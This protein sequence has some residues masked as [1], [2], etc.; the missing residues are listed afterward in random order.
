MNHSSGENASNTPAASSELSTVPRRL[1]VLGIG[2]IMEEVGKGARLV[3]RYP[4]S[5]PPFFLDYRRATDAEGEANGN[6][7]AEHQALCN[8]SPSNASKKKSRPGPSSA[9]TSSNE[10]NNLSGSIDLF[11]DLPARV[12]SKLFRPK[13]PLCGQPLTLNV[14]GTTFCCRAELFDSQ[15][16]TIGVGEDFNHPLVLFSVIVA[17][18]PL[19]PSSADKEIPLSHSSQY[20]F[21]FSGAINRDANAEN[22]QTQSSST[23]NSRSDGAFKTIRCV[24]RNLA[25]LCRV[26]VR[27]ENR[28]RYVSRQCNM[29]QKIRTDY[30]L[31]SS[32][33]STQSLGSDGGE[34]NST[35]AGGEGNSKKGEGTGNTSAGPPPLSPKHSA[36]KGQD[37]NKSNVDV[38]DRSMDC[39]RAQRREY[40][41]N[42]IDIL[43]AASPPA[44]D[45]SHADGDFAGR[46]QHGNLA[47]ELAQVFH[48][49]ASP[50]ATPHAFL[51]R[52]TAQDGVVYI[53]RHIAVPFDAVQAHQS[54]EARSPK[55]A[56]RPYHTLLFPNSSPVEV[57]KGLTD[58]HS[59]EMTTSPS[60]SH[61]LRRILPHVQPRKSL[62]EIGWDAGLALPHVM[63]AA[64]L[65]I[66]SGICMAA[67]PVVRKNRYACAD[68]VVP[69]MSS[70]ALPFWQTFGA[71]SKHCKFHWGDAAAGSTG[72]DD[73][74]TYRKRNVT[75]GAPHIFV[76]VSALT[77]NSENSSASPTL[78]EAVDLLSGNEPGLDES[79]GDQTPGEIVYSM[80][81]WLM[82]NK[83]IVE[84]E[85]CLV[86]DEASRGSD[87]HGNK[88]EPSHHPVATSSGESLYHELLQSGCLDGAT[89]I[90][91]ICYRFGL[92]RNRIETLLSSC[93]HRLKVVRHVE[94]NNDA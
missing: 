48:C 11:F 76:V 89:S 55:K 50:S 3:F 34:A 26:L 8:K 69:R 20:P 12:L 37:T 90:P 91:A 39:P 44:V 75:T 60:I 30:I 67:M 59:N 45:H 7:M 68:R 15:P 35:T 80:A 31:S 21:D 36:S 9:D 18:A 93:T 5:P 51:S 19:G 40:V 6:N 86:A 4:S 74:T 77:T 25:R 73:G 84:L 70:V 65:L 58:E 87:N 57:L 56:C 14:S 46:D 47:R 2:L 16:S 1:G 62:H 63:D 92:D 10:F 29:L 17:L 61:S 78:G 66:R 28:C 54:D 38:D 83:V 32:S 33:S 64:N 41:Q 52:A 23:Q 85:D 82:A 53:N 81:V 42:L 94:G 88:P 49:I 43:L 27:E 79:I 72:L 71:R 22:S 13:R 24:H